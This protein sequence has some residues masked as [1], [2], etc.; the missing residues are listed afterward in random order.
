[1][2]KIFVLILSIFLITGCMDNNI[3]NN[4]SKRTI[5]SNYCE[6]KNIK[7]DNYLIKGDN[8]LKFTKIPERVIVVG[9]S[10]IESMLALGLKEKIVMAQSYY[11]LKSFLK[12]QNQNGLETLP[13]AKYGSLSVE[14]MLLLQPDLLIAQQ[15]NFTEHRFR[16]TDFW[17]SR[18]IATYIPLNTNN[19]ASHIREE[20]IEKEMLFIEGLGQIFQKEAEADKIISDTYHILD[21]VRKNTVSLP[22][23]KTLIIEFMGKYIA[24]YDK[25]KL[26]GN[27]ASRLGAD[28][29]ETAPVIGYEELL[30]IDPEVIFVV[31]S[32]DDNG[33]CIKR[34]TANPAMRNLKALKNNR[35]YSIQLEYIYSSEAR[36]SDGLRIMAQSLYPELKGL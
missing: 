16:N 13:L 36:T 4:S 32:D 24:S 26:A 27:M 21:I 3:V 14:S 7:V 22:K 20:T 15:C 25:T 12:V 2:I 34:I 28:I 31:C 33:A 8:L 17:N 35:V 11:D 6:I 9:P 19:P 1:M 5:S 10:E 23:Y 18:D 30:I 29:P